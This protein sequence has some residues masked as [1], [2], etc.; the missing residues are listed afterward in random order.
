[1]DWKRLF[2]R[3]RKEA[4]I[5]EEIQSHLRMAIQDRIERGDSPEQAR[6]SALRE[7]GNA[8]LV[9]EDTRAVW[10]WTALERLAQDL[11]YALR[12]MRHS[13][14]FAAVAVLSL[15]LGIGAN[16]A[17][18][19]VMNSVLLK[20]LP[21]ENS[22]RLV[23][24]RYFHHQS[25][26]REILRSSSGYGTASFSFATFEHLRR[27]S[28][29]LSSVFA[30]V[31]TGTSNQSLTVSR[32][33]EPS[34]AAGE[35]VSG[36]YFSGLGVLP[37]L[38][39]AIVEEDE[40]PDRPAVAVIS[41]AYWS[42]R[43]ARDPA[44]IGSA[45]NLNRTPFTIVGVAPP[46]FFGINA[47]L[48]S[49]VWMPLRDGLGVGPWGDRP[50]PGESILT[51]NARW[52]FMIGG[53]LKP[54]IDQEQMHAELDLLFQRSITEGVSAPPPP[55]DLPQLEIIPASGG[56]NRLRIRFSEPL[57]VL[58]AAVGLVL[59][60]ACANVATLLLARAANRQKEMSVRLATG[61]SRGRLIR[62]L[63]TESLFLA[64]IGGGLGLLFA[65]W[66]SRVLLLLM[67]RAGESI[68]LDVRPDV[69]V[70]AFSA[71]VCI[72]AGTL[73][74][75]APAFRG[76]R[77]AL[78]RGLKGNVGAS[79]PRL[80]LG[81]ALVAGQVALSLLLLIG[82]G[83][84]L[85]TL[86]NLVRQDI[87]F[88]RSNLLLFALDARQGGR[89]EDGVT[90][91]YKEFLENVEAL[92]GVR[93]ASASRVAL[94]SGGRSIAP[95]S[96]DA[97]TVK[98]G[99]S[100]GIYFNR[101]GAAFFETLQIP[102]LLGRS[103]ERSDIQSSRKIAVVNE[104]LAQHFFP[105][106]SPLGRR[107]NFG[108]ARD[109]KDDYEIVGV[110]GNA[111]YAHLREDTPRTAY[112]PY[113]TPKG[114]LGQ[115]YFLVRTVGDPNAMIP[116]VREL[117]GRIDPGLPLINVKTQT[118]QIEESLTQDR[119]FARLTTFFAMLALLLVSIGLYGTL[120][121]AV[122]RRTNEIGIRMALGAQRQAVLRTV[123]RESLVL[124]LAGAAIGLPLAFATTRF[125]AS[126]LYGVEPNDFATISAA[127][128]VLIV[129]GMLAGYLPARR[130]ARVEPIVALRYEV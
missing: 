53:R 7:L 2:S 92:P 78:S 94:L 1:M 98:S 86:D 69:T 39:R 106:E 129:I 48:A 112:V 74:G 45:I 85:R 36:G 104:A 38:G 83:L 52:Q 9:K 13:P 59:L 119:M 68:A 97:P 65:H 56:L 70:L 28:H 47:E 23:L 58:M 46:E 80:G 105:K 17:V 116:A 3:R 6:T 99:E 33:G 90:A 121:Y 73:F 22:E 27:H 81:K 10:A 62:Q 14:G 12:Q 109:L 44:V 88:E 16:T 114:S 50:A 41:H 76:T 31:P 37:I 20:S 113:T 19:S 84:F 123:L 64:A 30:F 103:I 29:T 117:V 54:G 32:G 79:S 67:S 72:L 122:T 34:L 4:E 91:V 111:K 25:I 71:A 43:F 82:A 18:F 75:L 125:I 77:V 124:I 100:S 51:D 8:G 108:S 128:L 120:A 63:L 35:M 102:L 107:F 66:G 42:R 15:A 95:I 26:P 5:D 87:G 126:Q 127:V 101:V 93:S 115:L 89:T 130:A 40:K 60:I 61:A 21:V 49:D 11:K 57:W 24:L 96:T 110:V 118:D 55:E